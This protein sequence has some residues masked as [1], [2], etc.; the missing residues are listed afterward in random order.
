MVQMVAGGTNLI[1]LSWGLSSG[2]AQNTYLHEKPS[3]NIE[4]VKLSGMIS[5]AV[6]SKSITLW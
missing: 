4:D 5:V 2:Q 1:F 6:I 3:T